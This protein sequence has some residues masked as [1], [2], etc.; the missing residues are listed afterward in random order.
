[1]VGA[2]EV[3]DDH[4]DQ[5]A[6]PAVGI[7]RRRSTPR[8]KA[9]SSSALEI[10]VVDTSN[11]DSNRADSNLEVNSLAALTIAAPKAEVPGQLG[12]P[13]PAWKT[14]SSC[15]VNLSRNIATSL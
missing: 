8:R 12:L 11:A 10:P 15:L 6:R 7:C 2:V 9:E 13:N 1:V 14:K 5:G 3:A 4:P